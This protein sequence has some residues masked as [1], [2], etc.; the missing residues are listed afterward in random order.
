[1]AQRPALGG[2]CRRPRPGAVVLAGARLRSVPRVGAGAQLSGGH[3][4]GQH[5]RVGAAGV[6]E[7]G[8]EQRAGGE[9]GGGGPVGG[10]VAV[11][12]GVLQQGR[13]DGGVGAQVAGGG[14]GGQGAEQGDADGAAGL[15][16]GVDQRG[17]DAG[18]LAAE[19][20]GAQADGGGEDQ[21]EAEA[22]DQQRAEDC[23]GVAAGHGQAGQPGHAGGAGEHA[24]RQ[25]QPRPDPGQQHVRAENSAGDGGGDHGQERQPGA[26]R[27]VGLDGLQVV[28]QEQ[29]Y[30][31]DPGAGQ[32]QRDD[33]GGAVAVGE[34]PQRQQ[35]RGGPVL[36]AGER[37]EQ[38]GCAG[39]GQPGGGRVPAAGLGAG[40]PEDEQEQPGGDQDGAG[41][42]DL[43]PVR[44]AVPAPQE[45]RRPDQPDGGKGQVDIQRPAPV[46]VLGQQAAEQQADRAGDPGD[47][48]EDRERAAAGRAASER[49]GDDRQRGRGEQRPERALGGPPSGQDSEVRRRAGQRRRGG[50]PGQAGHEGAVAAEPVRQLPAEQQQAAERQR[51]GGYHPLAVRVGERQ[52]PL[53]R[54]QRDVHHGH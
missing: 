5:G 19:P 27:G 25:G 51:I 42:V 2:D 36:P 43:G 12:G 16:G 45:R 22:E 54:R 35:R 52:P 32:G 8:G 21:A 29:E 26:D 48:A 14:A 18:V 33:R 23:G 39:Q 6:V 10:G 4:A 13:G 34:H 53:R 47:R 17:S 38:D 28:G 41:Q 50:E 1:M 46:Q 44:R 3:V 11:D 20:G 49:R 9:D 40:Q 31:V 30:R 37:G 7:Q 24:G 15:L